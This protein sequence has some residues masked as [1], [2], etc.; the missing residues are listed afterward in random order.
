MDRGGRDVLEGGGEMKRAAVMILVGALI[1]PIGTAWATGNAASEAEHTRLAQEM[2]SLSDRGAWRGVE[3]NYERMLGLERR[4]V[5]LSYED[6]LLGA[7][8]ARDLG[9][10]TQVYQR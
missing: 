8:A 2:R 1:S 10:I 6:H 7:Q 9:R 3:A 4:G 5:V